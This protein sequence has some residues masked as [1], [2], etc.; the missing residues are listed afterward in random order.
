MDY[1]ES[2]YAMQKTYEELRKLFILRKACKKNPA[3]HLQERI[4]EIKDY[5]LYDNMTPEE[6]ID[7]I[8]QVTS[9]EKFKRAVLNEDLTDFLIAGDNTLTNGLSLPFKILSSVFKGLRQGE[10]MAFAMPSN[11]GKSRFNNRFFRIW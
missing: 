10:T 4:A 1:Q 5:E 2:K 9:T 8:D 11:Y 6:V 7:A 3:R